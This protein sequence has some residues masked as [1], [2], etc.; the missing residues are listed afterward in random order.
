MLVALQQYYRDQLV[1]VG[2]SIDERPPAEVKTFAEGFN[3]NYPVVM[4]TRELE[5]AFGGI[6][7]VP[8]TFVVNPDGKIVQRHLGQLQARRTEHEVRALA[9]LSTEATIETVAD[10]LPTGVSAS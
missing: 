8:S 3:V 1:I 6:S 10:L 2:V 5:Q 7:A 4:S 9:G